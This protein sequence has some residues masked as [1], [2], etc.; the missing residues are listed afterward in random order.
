MVGRRGNGIGPFRD[1]TGTGY[2][3]YDFCTGKMSPDTRFCALSYFDLNSCACLQIIRM[4]TKTSGSYLYDGIFSI[5]VKI[6]MQSAFSGV[7]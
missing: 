6:F 4:D 3:S 2:I 5:A 1:H 7:I